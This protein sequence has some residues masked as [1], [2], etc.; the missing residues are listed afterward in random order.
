MFYNE[1]KFLIYICIKIGIFSKS[2]SKNIENTE[3][4]YNDL[5][6]KFVYNGSGN[7]IGETVSIFDDIVIIKSGTKFLG[8]PIK[9][10]EKNDKT[11]LVKGLVDFTKAYE[12]GEKWRKKSY[13]NIDINT[14]TKD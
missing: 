5:L 13:N 3:D 6:C 9:H 11:L 10:I 7:K 14:N 2:K 12:L 4:K 1:F 8:V